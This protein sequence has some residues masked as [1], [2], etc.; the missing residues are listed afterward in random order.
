MNNSLYDAWDN[1]VTL[2]LIMILLTAAVVW[3]LTC[4]LW[5]LSGTAEIHYMSM[6]KTML[7]GGKIF[8]ESLA[9]EA[10]DQNQPLAFWLWA[11][12]IKIN[13]GEINSFAPRLISVIFAFITLVCTYFCGR[14]LINPKA[15]L[16]GA[17]ILATCPIFLFYAVQTAP[18]MIFAGF[19]ALSLTATL[20][21]PPEKKVGIVRAI[22]IWGALAAAFLTN[23]VLALVMTLIFFILHA[24]TRRRAFHATLAN[25]YFIPGIIALVVVIG[26]WLLAGYRL[27]G[28]TYIQALLQSQLT[29]FMIKLPVEHWWFYFTQI[30]FI[31]GIWVIGFILAIITLIIHKAKFLPRW[32]I[33]LFWF[34]PGFLLLCLAPEKNTAY[35]LPVLPPVAIFI[36][37]YISALAHF[38]TPGKKRIATSFAVKQIIL[39]IGVVVCVAALV[40]FVQP[41]FAWRH[42]FYVN[43]IGLIA[44]FVVGLILIFVTLRRRDAY[45]QLG[46]MFGL[47]VITLLLGNFVLNATVNPA[48]DVHL[49]SRYFSQNLTLMYPELPDTGLG[50]VTGH[51][52][53]D[54]LN[55]DAARFHLYGNYQLMP[56]SFAPDMFANVQT[57]ALPEFILMAAQDYDRLTDQPQLGGFA[58]VFWDTLE[59]RYDLILLKRQTSVISN[60]NATLPLIYTVPKPLLLTAAALMPEPPALTDINNTPDKPPVTDDITDATQT[61]QP[62]PGQETTVTEPDDEPLKQDTPANKTVP[63]EHIE[64]NSPTTKTVE[65]VTETIT[66]KTLSQGEHAGTATA[67]GQANEAVVTEE[68]ATDLP[69]VTEKTLIESQHADEAAAAEPVNEAQSVAALPANDA[70]SALVEEPAASG[71]NTTVPTTPPEA[72]LKISLWTW[73]QQV[74]TTRAQTLPEVVGME[75][76]MAAE[77][78]VTSE[79]PAANS[80]LDT[81]ANQPDM[82]NDSL[83]KDLYGGTPN[84]DRGVADLE[85]LMQTIPFGRHD[86]DT[87]AAIITPVC[88]S[89]EKCVLPQGLVVI[90]GML[91]PYLANCGGRNAALLDVNTYQPNLVRVFS[92]NMQLGFEHNAYAFNWLRK[93]TGKFPAEYNLLALNNLTLGSKRWAPFGDN[94]TTWMLTEIARD[95]GVRAVFYTGQDFSAADILAHIQKLSAITPQNTAGQAVTKMQMDFNSPDTSLTL[96]FENAP[97]VIVKMPR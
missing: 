56:V 13:G 23:G 57:P 85:L 16:Y 65:P 15:G 95:I 58:P 11:L 37:Y 55:A 9:N 67:D 39:L 1:N 71:N 24:V 21:R 52:S 76:T 18:D 73:L 93:Q 34:A 79:A 41:D 30:G 6:V 63:A 78:A 94:F 5:S 12:A 3:G 69:E 29:L 17:F 46:T 51:N 80:Q 33:W 22:T 59:N 82:K 35:I 75:T 42:G 26:L 66:D 14:R 50:A 10:L 81:T 48:L 60:P 68:T 88:L 40:I 2:H 36:G 91:R 25:L 45:A 31:L 7:A 74:R 44:A 28:D 62:V 96:E 64:N 61:Q 84:A 20:T 92:V 49:T 19:I 38:T 47:V 77:P 89:S 86:N 72:S 4:G 83:M 27:A 97:P 90:N 70:A 32:Y 53:G 43:T 54:G 8:N 87:Q